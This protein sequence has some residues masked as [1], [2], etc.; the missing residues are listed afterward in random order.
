MLD[1]VYKRAFG[2]KTNDYIEDKTGN[3]VSVLTNKGIRH[4]DVSKIDKTCL[5]KFNTYLSGNLSEH[6]GQADKNGQYKVLSKHGVLKPGEA[7]SDTYFVIGNFDTEQE[8]LNCSKF[9]CTKLLRILVLMKASS[10]IMSPKVFTD[11]P[12]QD[13]T[14]SSDIDWTQSIQDIDKQLYKKY[15][16]SQEEIDYIERTI[17]PMS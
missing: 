5:N 10:V 4:K 3:L 17:K 8:A 9:M 16:L 11:V 12:L 13:F 7:C 14:S 2:I 6:A 1:I 15:N